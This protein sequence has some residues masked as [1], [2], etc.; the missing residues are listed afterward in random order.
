M[1]F[2]GDGYL[3]R[4]E[5]Y[6]I[7]APNSKTYTHNYDSNKEYIYEF[8]GRFEVKSSDWEQKISVNPSYLEL[9]YTAISKEELSSIFR[10]IVVLESNHNNEQILQT[11]RLGVEL[12][13]YFLYLVIILIVLEMVLS[14]QFYRNK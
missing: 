4:G 14:N 3:K 10:N 1:Q 11:T 9:N 8:P 7:N 13:K 12:W 6:T 2:V 5:F